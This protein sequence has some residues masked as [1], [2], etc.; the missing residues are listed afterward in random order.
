M[1]VPGD[2][3]G[4]G[5]SSFV[6]FSQLGFYPVTPGLPMYVIGSPVFESATLKLENGKTFEVVCHNYSPTNKFI[7]S[8]KLNG[9]IWNKSWFSHSELMNG[10]RLEFTMGKYPNKKWASGDESIPPSFKY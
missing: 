6:V 5:L 7:Q 3:D 1:G 2:E 8:A 10:G 4:G 9:Q